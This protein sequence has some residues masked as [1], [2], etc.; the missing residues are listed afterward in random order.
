MAFVALRVLRVGPSERQA[1]ELIPEAAAW[2]NARRLMNAGML[3]EVEDAVV[4]LFVHQLCQGIP[5]TALTPGIH[6]T[7][8]VR[9]ARRM[10]GTHPVLPVLATPRTQ[11]DA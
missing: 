9:A 10:R 11:K 1:G 4:E 8:L 5:P 3:A 6:R 2:P 7:H